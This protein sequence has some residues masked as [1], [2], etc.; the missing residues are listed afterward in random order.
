MQARAWK[1]DVGNAAEIK[2]LIPAIA[3]ELGGLDIIVNNAGISGD[4]G[5]RR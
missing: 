4:I 3:A 1:L 2:S 5:D